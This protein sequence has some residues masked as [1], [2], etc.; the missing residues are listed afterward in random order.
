MARKQ[1]PNIRSFLKQ[2]RL[3][4]ENRLEFIVA[5]GIYFLEETSTSIIILIIIIINL[6]QRT[7]L[8]QKNILITKCGP[9]QMPFRI[10]N[11]DTEK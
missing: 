6:F 3:K 10:L 2:I 5:M 4:T 7:E 1:L 8:P 9:L 11:C